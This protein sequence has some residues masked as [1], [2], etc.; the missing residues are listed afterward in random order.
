MANETA[1]YHIKNEI[2]KNNAIRN[3]R[4]TY[5]HTNADGSISIF[6]TPAVPKKPS[7]LKGISKKPITQPPHFKG[8]GGRSH[9]R[10]NNPR[11]SR[12]RR[13]RSSTKSFKS[14]FHF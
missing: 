6:H 4:L 12:S 8:I 7:G 9:R 2:A 11:G 1:N 3:K 10:K 5:R 14:L 13:R